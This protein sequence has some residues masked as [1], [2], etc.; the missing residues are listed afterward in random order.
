MCSTF[1]KSNIRSFT[2]FF[3]FWRLYREKKNPFKLARRGLLSK[4]F[5]PKTELN[6][7]PRKVR[8]SSSEKL[9]SGP[10]QFH[11]RSP[12]PFLALLFWV[13]SISLKTVSVRFEFCKICKMVLLRGDGVVNYR[14]NYTVW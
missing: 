8:G 6:L 11:L 4:P 12:E 5:L 1:R 7:E 2:C 10:S 13:C 3:F 14:K 9:V